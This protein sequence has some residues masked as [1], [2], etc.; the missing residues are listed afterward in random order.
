MKTVPIENLYVHLTMFWCFIERFIKESY[1][2][3]NRFSTGK[4]LCYF[5]VRKH[6]TEKT[7]FFFFFVRRVIWYDNVNWPH[8]FSL[9]GKLP[10]IDIYSVGLLKVEVSFDCDVLLELG[11]E[12]VEPPGF[13]RCSW[14][15]ALVCDSKAFT[16]WPE[17]D[18][19]F[20]QTRHLARCTFPSIFCKQLPNSLFISQLS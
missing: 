8:Y 20:E 16:P 10:C 19:V 3:H 5:V 17:T 12:M 9:C 11:N 4:V 13:G 6:F 2:F 7:P 14:C 18:I 1:M 15:L